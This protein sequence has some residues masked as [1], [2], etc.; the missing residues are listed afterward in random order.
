MYSCRL[1]AS[2][3]LSPTCLSRQDKAS[4]QALLRRTASARHTACSPGRCYTHWNLTKQSKTAG[5]QLAGTLLLCPRHAPS[6]IPNILD[7]TS[8]LRA[9][10][11]PNV[12]HSRIYYDDAY[13]SAGCWAINAGHR[14]PMAC[15]AFKTRNR[16]RLVDAQDLHLSH[17]S[18]MSTPMIQQ[19]TDGMAD[20]KTHRG[21]G[22]QVQADGGC[23]TG[24]G[25]KEER[26]NLE[27][28]HL[29]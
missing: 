2:I 14:H 23:H 21:H 28:R 11:K 17:P 9:G 5:E 29:D 6:K 26:D 27:G 19:V 22:G 24:Q 3:A 25:G 1:R 15:E 10:A 8:E 12:L 4:S 18:E 13:V 20:G 16:C 7:C